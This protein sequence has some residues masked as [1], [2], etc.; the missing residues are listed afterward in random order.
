MREKGTG[1]GSIYYSK[2]R[3]QF[4]YQ[5]SELD[6]ITGK[7]R[8]KIK[9]FKT[10]EEAENYRKSLNYQKENPLFIEYNGLPLGELMKMNLNAKLQTNQISQVQYDRV[11]RTQKKIQESYLYNKKIDEIKSEEIQAFLNSLT[12]LS[13]SSIKKLKEQ[14]GQA[15]KYAINRGYINVNPMS[16]VLTPKSTK[17]DKRVRALTFDEQEKFVEWLIKQ[18][19]NEFPYRNIFLIQMFMG[20]RIGEVLALRQ[21]DIDL[22]N[23]RIRISKTLT[24][25]ADGTI[26]MSNSPKT[27]AGNREVPIVPQILPY[28]MEQIEVSKRY[29]NN[30]DEKLLFRPL[31]ATKNI[32]VDRENVNNT[33]KTTLKRNFG[34]EGITTHSLR[35]TYGTR[36]I[37][38]GM[39]PTVVQRN[40]GHTDITITLNIYA[41]VF[42]EFKQK[43]Q[44]KFNDYFMC[45]NAFKQIP[46]KILYSEEPNDEEI[47]R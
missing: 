25:L 13:N 24:T 28:I 2:D 20:L 26:T 38:A 43:E 35:H 41:D 29:E 18:D 45:V 16:I 47:S 22:R 15:F 3:K 10:L 36:C 37:E 32:Y 8:R 12:Y 17:K 39:Q 33:L 7:Q 46:E 40:M 19:I 44:E 42:D 11:L 4:V 14:F 9:R 23:N 6:V 21:G 27:E 34:I 31:N 30:K 1:N 5:Y